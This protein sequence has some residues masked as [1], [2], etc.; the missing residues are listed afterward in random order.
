MSPQPNQPM[1]LSGW[2]AENCPKAREA[3][4]DYNLMWPQVYN[5]HLEKMWTLIEIEDYRRTNGDANALLGKLD[6]L[7]LKTR[8][9]AMPFCWALPPMRK[10]PVQF[11]AI[12]FQMRRLISSGSMIFRTFLSSPA[13]VCVRNRK[14]NGGQ[15]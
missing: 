5:G 15:H 13:K 4:I 6:L 14:I 7:L 12:S 11:S 1:P 8:A 3:V 9:C 10:F 2:I